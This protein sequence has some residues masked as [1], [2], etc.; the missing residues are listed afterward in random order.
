MGSSIRPGYLPSPVLQQI[1]VTTDKNDPNTSVSNPD[2]HF[3]PSRSVSVF[4]GQVVAQAI[5]AAHA[6]VDPVLDI[7]SIHCTFIDKTDPKQALIYRVSNI[8]TGN[9]IANRLVNVFQHTRLV[10][11]ATMSFHRFEK[12][13]VLKH[14]STFLS[15][16]PSFEIMTPVK[17]SD[18]Y[19]MIFQ[20]GLKE[21]DAVL[22]AA[23]EVKHLMPNPTDLQ[24]EF[25][26]LKDFFKETPNIP[27]AGTGLSKTYRF[28]EESLRSGSLAKVVAKAPSAT[29]KI[30]YQ[31]IKINGELPESPG[32][33]TAAFAFASD[34]FSSQLPAVL[35]SNKNLL[36]IT[37]LDHTI[38][39]HKPFNPCDWLA[40]EN[41]VS[42]ADG[43]RSLVEMRYW[44]K[45]GELVATA[46]Q[47][48]LFRGKP[49]AKL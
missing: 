32:H 11:M 7:H 17:R 35:I 13:P 16:F 33:R 31:Y 47:E 10:F 18:Y 2:F 23:L 45:G 42:V 44:N 48:G 30:I 20:D 40:V 1:E 19:Q 8:R 15:N 41:I 21:N 9:T 5:L 39:F 6:T 12:E 27:L 43:G 29:S 4:G 37:S 3:L 25:G 14:N 34:A 36:W 22:L 38:Y 26:K 49:K 24:A 46:M 28:F